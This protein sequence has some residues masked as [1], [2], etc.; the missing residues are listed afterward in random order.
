MKSYFSTHPDDYK[1]YDTQTLR[2]R[3]LIEKLFKA[4][5][6]NQFYCY[7]DRLIVA[8]ICPTLSPLSLEAGKALGGLTFFARREAAAVNVGGEGVITV[9]GQVFSLLERDALYI[10]KGEHDVQFESVNPDNPARFYF[11]SAPSHQPY[12]T[13][14]IRREEARKIELGDPQNA[15]ERIINQ[16][17]HPDVCPS[18]Q[19]AMGLTELKNCSIW[20]TMPCHTHARRMEAYF[21]FFEEDDTRVFHFMGEPDETRHLVVAN[22]Q[23][24]VSPSWSIHSGVGTKLTALSGRWPEKT[25]SLMIWILLTRQTCAKECP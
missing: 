6:V 21:Y 3:Y 2:D 5:E 7:D 20:N 25:R 17:I 9:N 10:G 12:P 4:G 16:Y 14:L 19:L 8:G 24:V 18:S 1:Q 13:R 23:V 22:E 15:N 11:C